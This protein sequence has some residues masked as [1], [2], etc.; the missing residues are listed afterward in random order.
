MEEDIPQDA[1]RTTTGSPNV[2]YTTTGTTPAPAVNGQKKGKARTATLNCDINHYASEA[3]ALIKDHPRYAAK[4]NPAQPDNWHIC[5]AARACGFDH[6]TD[7]NLGDVF[8]AI[9][10]R[11]QNA[12]SKGA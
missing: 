1:P 2:P 3:V 12:E 6:I 7:D 9:R 8:A 10:D 4:D 5:A 11:A